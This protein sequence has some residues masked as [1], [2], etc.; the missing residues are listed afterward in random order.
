MQFAVESPR[1]LSKVLLLF[2]S[3]RVFLFFDLQADLFV[4]YSQVGKWNEAE[5]VVRSIWGKENI[6]AAIEELK[7]AAESTDSQSEISWSELFTEQ[8]YKGVVFY[9]FWCQSKGW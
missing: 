2:L 4:T 6:E 1:W 8:Y 3:N 5:S 7:N 9:A